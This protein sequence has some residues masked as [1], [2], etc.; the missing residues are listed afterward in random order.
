MRI[1]SLICCLLSCL[2]VNGSLATDAPWDFNRCISESSAYRERGELK[3]AM[4]SLR[5]AQARALNG[6]ELSQTNSQ[7]GATLMEGRHYIEA[8]RH[9]LEA[10]KLRGGV[11]R[12]R[13]AL[14]LGNLVMRRGQAAMAQAYFQESIDLS[15]AD[16]VLRESATLNL[17]RLLGQ[18][19]RLRML[20]ALSTR[21]KQ[22]DD[23]QQ[24]ARLR[25]NLAGQARQLGAVELAYGQLDAARGALTPLGSNRL[26]VE[27]L[28]MLA[29][30]YEEQGRLEDAGLINEEGLFHA[31]RIAARAAAEPLVNLNWRK[32]R[33]ARRAGLTDTALAALQRAADHMEKIRSSLPIAYDD[34]RSVYGTLIEPL[35]LELLAL[36][37]AESDKA[38]PTT[39]SAYLRKA[40]EIVEL[41]RQAEMQDFLGDRCSVDG[42]NSVV[43][44]GNAAQWPAGTAALYPILLSTHTELL[45]ETASGFERQSVAVDGSTLR[46]EAQAFSE[47]LRQGDPNYMAHAQQLYNWLIRPVDK[48]LAEEQIGT[49]IIVPNG[50]LRLVAIGAL[51]DGERYLIEKH[52]LAS[53]TGLSMTQ[54]NAPRRRQV[55]ALVAGLSTPGPVVD[56]IDR[57]ALQRI[58]D[59]ADSPS[60][61]AAVQPGNMRRI[62]GVRQ[63]GGRGTSSESLREA[64][65]L[66]GVAEEVAAVGA[67][68][69]GTRLLDARFTVDNFSQEAEN[70]EYRILHIASHGVFG[71][72]AGSSFILAYDDVLS[73]NGLQSLLRSDN[74]R[75]NPLE[76]LGLSAC[77]TAEGNDRAPLGIAGAAIKARARSVL[78]TLW[79]VEDTSAR[80]LM[81]RFYT[82][83]SRDGLTKSEALR[84]AQTSL[85]H[86]RR[87]EHP[88][89]WAP[90]TLIGNWQ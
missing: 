3:R 44:G 67:T 7:L 26:L 57:Q 2:I 43:D 64:L 39:R 18:A 17:A 38:A 33:L 25:I 69:K 47:Q 35:H 41:S 89:Y 31:G 74:F 40:R 12:A 22:I 24:Q 10:Y 1:L 63:A 45:L 5:D 83:I 16:V 65:A 9:L 42:L 29:Q 87:Y 50:V 60:R 80:L 34:G 20:E 84:A 82:G 54:L 49:L 48:R 75:K 66:P 46:G 52:A 56:K 28:D 86:D 70:G 68:L 13:D 30:I 72:D 85:I 61:Q 6:S 78:G 53:A 23:P 81:E 36:L 79:P 11:E 73:L 32:G 59:P 27:G 58:Q 8:E 77:Q 88:L 51:H 71:G 37:F 4:E 55:R 76:I 14:L 21:L 19:E 90:Y 62:A 15:G